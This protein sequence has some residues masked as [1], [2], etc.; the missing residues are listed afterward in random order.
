MTSTIAT[1]AA[2]VQ[3]RLRFTTPGT[4]DPSVAE[5]SDYLRLGFKHL[6]G[7]LPVIQETSNATLAISTAEQLT[8]PITSERVFYV[9]SIS[10]MLIRGSEW[11]KIG[12]TIYLHRSVANVGEAISGWHTTATLITTGS[13][14]TVENNAIFGYDWLEEPATLYAEMMALGEMARNAGSASGTE[15]GAQYRAVEATYNKAVADRQAVYNQWVADMDRALAAR[16]S[17]GDTPMVPNRISGM[18]NLSE[19]RSPWRTTG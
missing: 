8:V 12:N 18:S 6:L 17:M 2:E 1:I 15:H 13:T 4:T 14:T 11:N 9:A 3:R 7:V 19:I 16:L 10:K 5:V